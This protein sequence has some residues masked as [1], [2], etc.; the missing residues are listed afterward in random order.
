LLLLLCQLNKLNLESSKLADPAELNP[1][2]T[3]LE[4]PKDRR[5]R[6]FVVFVTEFVVYRLFNLSL[7]SVQNSNISS[8]RGQLWHRI[9][10]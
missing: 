2:V 5:L 10:K 8:Q 9:L 6:K 4:Y 7:T 3:H 1:I